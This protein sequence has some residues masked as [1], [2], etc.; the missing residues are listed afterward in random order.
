MKRNI[1]DAYVPYVEKNKP[2]ALL[3]GLIAFE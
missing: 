2:W 3:E 1:P